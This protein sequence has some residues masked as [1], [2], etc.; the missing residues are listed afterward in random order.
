MGNP[1]TACA[2]SS[3]RSAC[4]SAS[5]RRSSRRASPCCASSG[6][7]E[8]TD[9]G[10]Y[11]DYDDV[12]FY[13]GT[14][15]G[16]LM[17]VQAAPP[18]WVISNIGWAADAPRRQEADARRLQPRDPLRRRL[19]DL[20]PG[21]ASRG[22]G[23]AAPAMRKAA[24]ELG[25]DIDRYTVSYQVTMNIGDSAEQASQR[26]RRL[27]LQVLP[28]A[29]ARRWTS[30]T[31]GPSGTPR[32]RADWLRFAAAGVDHF[33]C[34]FG[35]IDQFGQVERFEKCSAFTGR[36]RAER[37]G[38]TT[39]EPRPKEERAR[40]SWSSTSASRWRTAT[41]SRSSR[42]PGQAGRRSSG[43]WSSSG[44][45]CHRDQ[46]RGPDPP[47]PCRHAVPDGSAEESAPGDGR[48]GPDD[49]RDQPR[50]GQPLRARP[51]RQGDVANGQHRLDR[52]GHRAAGRPVAEIEETRG[53]EKAMA[54]LEGKK[55]CG[56]PGGGHGRGGQHR[57]PALA[58]GDAAEA[59]RANDGP[60]ASLG[61]GRI[62]SCRG[63]DHRH[64]RRRRRDARDRPARPGGPSRSPGHLEERKHPV[65]A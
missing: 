1:S 8:R 47:G 38:L 40:P 45:A 28:R 34:R 16:P 50:V 33:I 25:D 60:G 3:R 53:R 11:Y 30:P 2:V 35:A 65:G 21:A 9:H 22:A 44:A 10:E 41:S 64:D 4:R 26:V 20:L 56:S 51:R 49:H 15:M 48:L 7:R 39:E 19:D 6:R 54:G 36:H 43:R 63:S 12:S 57:G 29:L 59:A 14:E 42:R 17:P 31:G 5:A 61:R 23:R 58:R 37:H 13:S 27:H 32:D 46:Q 62:R 52:R 24:D 55:Q 18:I